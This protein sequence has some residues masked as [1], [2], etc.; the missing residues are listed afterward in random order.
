MTGIKGLLAVTQLQNHKIMKANYHP[1]IAL[2]VFGL[3]AALPSPS[4]AADQKEVLGAYEAVSQALAKDDLPAARKAA[5]ELAEKAK[6]ADD[7][8]LAMHA[9]GLAKSDS[10]PKAREH[11]E[12]ASQEVL[13]LAQGQAGYYHL[14]CPMA[15]KD[16]LQSNKDVM[17]PY[18]GKAMQNCGTV[19]DAAQ[20]SSMSEKKGTCPM[21]AGAGSS[22]CG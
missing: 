6:A 20:K 7:K 13:K 5:A 15:N 3:F 17:N 16:W 1:F 14:H 2:F 18:L 4:R 8:P 9:G 10:L 12:A 22:C 11:F 19:L 21:M